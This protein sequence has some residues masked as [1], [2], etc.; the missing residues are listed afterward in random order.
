V[1]RDCRVAEA[2][3]LYRR[4]GTLCEK[5]AVESPTDSIYPY[6]GS[7]GYCN[8]AILLAAAHR[9]QEAE[10][11]SR[12]VLELKPGD[13]VVHYQFA[14]L[15]LHLGDR[16]GHRKTCVEMLKRF[17]SSD[18][19]A[20]YWTA[21]TCTLAPDAVTDWQPVVRLAEKSLGTDPKNCDKLQHLGAVLYRAGRFEE[22]AKW[23][24]EAETAL[25]ESP[26][27]RTTVVYS[28]LFLAMTQHRLGHAAEADK[29]LKKAM[30]EIDRPPPEQSQAAASSWNRRLTLQLLR[31]EAEELLK[32]K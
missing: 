24:T 9:P 28:Q 25:K 8:L 20:A 12:R 16:D 22:G 1:E 31:H 5:L 6:W 13:P 10:Q 30:Q 27:P 14:L 15:R 18:L 7:L 26:N 2:M 21:W 17:D 19:N 11:T 23:L 4:A 29:W 3:D 32:Q